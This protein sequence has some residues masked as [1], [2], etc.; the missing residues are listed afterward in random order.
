MLIPS[1][2]YEKG[3]QDPQWMTKIWIDLLEPLEKSEDDSMRIEH[4]R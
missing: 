2:S 3:F 1:G 4:Q